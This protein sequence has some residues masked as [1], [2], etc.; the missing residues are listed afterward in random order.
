[1]GI[2]RR[3]LLV[4]AVVLAVGCARPVEQ[5]V[6][7][8]HGGNVLLVPATPEAATC[9]DRC[10]TRKGLCFTSCSDEAC[11]LE[12]HGAHE[13]CV[14]DCPGAHWSEVQLPHQ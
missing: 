3:T 4:I 9:L 14:E 10:N 11:E 8:L 2:D 7:I 5:R 1:M 13:H 12:C 6:A